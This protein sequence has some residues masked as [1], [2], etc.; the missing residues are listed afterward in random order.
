MTSFYRAASLFVFLLFSIGSARADVTYTYTGNDYSTANFSY[1]TNDYLSGELTFTTALG[2]NLGYARVAAA[3]FSY[4]GG[5]AGD[6]F[7]DNNSSS[8]VFVST[9]A[10]GV[11]DRWYVVLTSTANGQYFVQNQ[12]SPDGA[13]FDQL[14]TSYGNAH[15]YSAGQWAVTVAAVPEPETYV[16]LLAGLGFT[17]VMTRRKLNV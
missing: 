3:S 8:A 16:M 7:T 5:V 10:I 14:V 12:Y 1:S 13:Q 2:D 15:V 9:N 11:I 17:C 4:T 6:T